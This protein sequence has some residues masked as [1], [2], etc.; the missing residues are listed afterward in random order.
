MSTRDEARPQELVVT[1]RRSGD[2][3]ADVDRLRLVH[4][5]LT[6]FQGA[7]RFKFRLLGDAQNNGSLELAFPNDR[8]RYCPELAHELIAILGPDCYH[9]E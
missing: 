8:T 3:S 9:L 1:I 7:N 6:E 5:L 4:E 2:H